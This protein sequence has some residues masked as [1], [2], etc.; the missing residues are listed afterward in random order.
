MTTDSKN[1]GDLEKVN[2]SVNPAVEVLDGEDQSRLS[3]WQYIK[4]NRR[5][6]GW[7]IYLLM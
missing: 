1:D 5:S 4:A 3:L 2:V 6:F 7:S